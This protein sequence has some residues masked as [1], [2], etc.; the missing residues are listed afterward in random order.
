MR[1]AFEKEL[2]FV[3]SS[4]NDT[5]LTTDDKGSAIVTEEELMWINEFI[6]NNLTWIE[7]NEDCLSKEKLEQAMRQFSLA[8]KPIMSK[9]YARKKQIDMANQYRD[10]DEKEVTSEQQQSALDNAFK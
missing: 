8:T 2:A 7:E 9:V 4:V 10:E 5:A 6:L 1:Y 3:Q